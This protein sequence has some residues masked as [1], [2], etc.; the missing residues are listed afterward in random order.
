MKRVYEEPTLR[1][2]E[3]KNMIGTLQASPE[4]EEDETV[5]QS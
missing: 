4:M 1:L 3:L 5:I 2:W